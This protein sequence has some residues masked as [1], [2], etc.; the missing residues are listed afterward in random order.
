MKVDKVFLSKLKSMAIHNWKDGCFGLDETE[1]VVYS[2]VKA[3]ETML[4]L[5]LTY[6]LP[7]QVSQAEED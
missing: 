3:L 5:N 1:L 4:K 2:Y 6:D 7:K